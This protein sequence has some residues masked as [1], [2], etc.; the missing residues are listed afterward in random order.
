MPRGI[1]S[2]GLL[3]VITRMGSV[4]GENWSVRNEE[5]GAFMAYLAISG[6]G[7]DPISENVRI[8]RRGKEL[9]ES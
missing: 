9:L 5:L 2:G 7:E 3:G 4:M 6:E 1:L 8:V